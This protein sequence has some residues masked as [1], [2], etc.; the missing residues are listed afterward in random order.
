M[1]SWR[2]LSRILVT[3]AVF[4][5]ACP[6]TLL[7]AESREAPKGIILLIGD[8][9]GINQVRSAAIYA[10]SVLGRSLAMDSIVTRGT[11]A[12]SSADS[13]VTDSA[14]ASTALYSGYKTRNGA[15]N[16]LPDGRRVSTIWHAAKRAGLS[17]GLV[18]TTRVTHATPAALYSHVPHRDDESLI[19][20]QLP[21][22]SMDVALGGGLCYFIPQGRPGSKRKDDKD[23]V[24]AMKTAGYTY[25]TNAEELK[26]LDFTA[27]PKLLGLF[28]MS[29]MA[30]E[31]DRLHVTALSN[32]PDLATMTQA[33]LSVLDRNPRGFCIMIEGGRIDHACHSHDIKASIYDT[34]AFDDAVRAALEYRKSRPDVLVLVTADHETGGMGL[35]TGT[36]YALHVPA[37]QAIRNSL[38][39]LHKRIEKHPAELENI[40]KSSG[41]ELTDS[42]RALLNS[43]PVDAKPGAVAELRPYGVAINKYIFSWVHYALGLIQGNRAGIGWTSFVHTA[44][45]VITY[46]VGPGERE[47]SGTYDNTEMARKMA[48]LLG[49]TLEGPTS[50]GA[51]RP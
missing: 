23:L 47:F 43:Y 8:G 30:Y 22:F 4:V 45:P 25:V 36:E 11:T 20:E 2:H 3:V 48:R 32:Q 42:E 28:S 6:V 13:E 41:F 7:H 15:I 34:L 44:Q 21:A 37:L 14:A 18:S 29:H 49:L 33:A 17:V 12:T 9:M 10:R 39:Y 46:A 40:L 16:I 35:G 26:D 27:V 38:E 19:A 24:E 1:T 5:T 31:I 50:S 51:I